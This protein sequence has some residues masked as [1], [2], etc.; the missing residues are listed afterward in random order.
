M[1]TH[2][3]NLLV[4]YNNRTDSKLRF[5]LLDLPVE[6]SC[7]LVSSC[8]V[9]VYILVANLLGCVRVGESCA[10]DGGDERSD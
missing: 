6:V 5:K 2:I 4:D 10:Y 9:C 1:H 8:V 3:I 7:F